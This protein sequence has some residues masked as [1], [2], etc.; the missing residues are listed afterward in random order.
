[1]A[2]KI[3]NYRRAETWQEMVERCPSTGRHEHASRVAGRMHH[4]GLDADLIFK[5]IY[6][7][8]LAAGRSEND[9]KYGPLD[10]EVR[11]I[12]K[13]ITRTDGRDYSPS[14]SVK[15]VQPDIALID[16]RV[17]ENFV[18]VSYQER[19]EEISPYEPWG[20]TAREALSILFPDDPLLWFGATASRGCLSRW[21]KFRFLD[22]QQFVSPN[23]FREENATNGGTTA[24][25]GGNLRQWRYAVAECDWKLDHSTWGPMLDRW[26][27]ESRGCSTQQAQ[28]ANLWPLL[29][30]NRV[31][32]VVDSGGKS[33]HFWL[34]VADIEDAAKTELCQQMMLLGCDAAI[35]KPVQFFRM[36]GGR[37]D[38]GPPQP[39][40]YFN[41]PEQ[42]ANNK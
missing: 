14:T 21:S 8:M 13:H 32:M 2:I 10:R 30:T 12:I 28:L 31:A 33:L 25:N 7:M 41:P 36:P 37:R 4:E 17:R 19:L 27:R 11:S 9:P 15:T 1:M 23:P 38:N 5:T 18:D 16:Q 6:D 26:N 24:R 22:R 40:L 34:Y 39:V 20:I 42:L 35:K 29:E 3:Q